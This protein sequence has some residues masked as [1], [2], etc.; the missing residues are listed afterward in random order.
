MDTATVG[1]DKSN[2]D[3][4]QPPVQRPPLPPR[5]IGVIEKKSSDSHNSLGHEDAYLSPNAA[6]SQ[7]SSDSSPEYDTVPDG[8]YIPASSHS[9]SSSLIDN[10]DLTPIIATNRDATHDNRSKKDSK[11]YKTEATI[12]LGLDNKDDSREIHVTSL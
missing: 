12:R 8:H 4:D 2:R 7:S 5:K 10:D 3:T 11:I 9:F 6:G 1:E